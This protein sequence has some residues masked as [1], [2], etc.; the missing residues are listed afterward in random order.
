M[1]YFG[2]NSKEQRKSV[3]ATYG[4]KPAAATSLKEQAP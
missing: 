3:A 4:I 1:F 2:K